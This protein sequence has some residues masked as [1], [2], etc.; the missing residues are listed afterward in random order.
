M[1]QHG[2]VGHAKLYGYEKV[3][4]LVTYLTAGNPLNRI[5][6]ATDA[7]Y[8]AVLYYLL[9]ISNS[10]VTVEPLGPTSIALYYACN[11]TSLYYDNLMYQLRSRQLLLVHDETI[12]GDPWGY[13]VRICKCELASMF[14]LTYSN[15]KFTLLT[16]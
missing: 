7:Y 1:L 16:R 5:I 8:S 3:Q 2:E 14:D 11:N 15:S 4:S 6:I 12:F 13:A 9:R 10:N